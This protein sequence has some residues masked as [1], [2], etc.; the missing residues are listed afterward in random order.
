MDYMK[1]SLDSGA[2]KA[3]YV[4]VSQV[5]FDPVLRT[6]CEA[7]SCGNYGKNHTCPP[8]AGDIHALIEKAKRYDH[9]LLFQTI[10][11][12]EDSLDYEGMVEAGKRNHEVIKKVNKALLGLG[13]LVLG[14]GGCPLCERCTARVNEPCRFP[15]EAITSL[16]AYGINVSTAAGQAGMKYINGA[17]TVTYF[18]AVLFNGDRIGE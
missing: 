14:A 10:G 2:D 16:E 3:G 7:N 13:A 4:K 11:Q 18:G 5:V 1:L 12:L 6:Y 9:M 8:G 17:N 15:E